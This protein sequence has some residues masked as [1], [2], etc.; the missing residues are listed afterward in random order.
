M[1]VIPLLIE[2]KSV[3]MH[4]TDTEDAERGLT[5]L[6]DMSGACDRSRL[7]VTP[8][9]PAPAFPQL[10]DWLPRPVIWGR[11]CPQPRAQRL[12]FAPQTRSGSPTLDP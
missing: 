10:V 8:P 2:P 7:P 6:S 11:G 4:P 3:H 5:D 9:A 1:S 12:I